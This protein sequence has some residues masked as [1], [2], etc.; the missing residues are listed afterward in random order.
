MFTAWPRVERCPGRLIAV[1]V[2]AVW[3]ISYSVVA[4]PHGLEAAAG[5]SQENNVATTAA[6]VPM[7]AYARGGGDGGIMLDAAPPMVAGRALPPPQLH[8][9]AMAMAMGGGGERGTAAFAPEPPREAM[10]A[11]VASI[12][13]EA[14]DPA[15]A[16]AEIAAKVSALGGTVTSQVVSSQR[17]SKSSSVSMSVRVPAAALD[18]TISF[19]GAR[20]LVTRRT[21]NA[22]DVTAQVRSCCWWMSRGVCCVSMYLCFLCACVY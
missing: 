22:D 9:A 10:I 11:R 4:D 16:G 2:L 6:P 17:D 18:A 13:M 12:D 19:V 21:I 20:G 15:T 3:V 8:G 7:A 5:D 1:A 14:V